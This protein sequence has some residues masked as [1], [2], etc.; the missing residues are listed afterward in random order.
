MT[1]LDTNFLH[2]IPNW[3]TIHKT[4]TRTM[5]LGILEDD[6][7]SWVGSYA[8]RGF[9]HAPDYFKTWTLKI[10]NNH[11]RTLRSAKIY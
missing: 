11:D 8:R 1:I 9:F 2:T 10:L 7:S 6:G 4:Y 5:G 3:I